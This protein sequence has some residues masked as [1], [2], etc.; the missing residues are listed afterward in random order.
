MDKLPEPISTFKKT[1]R[2]AL[3]VGGFFLVFVLLAIDS[4]NYNKVVEQS[5]LVEIK[6]T[7][8]EKPYIEKGRGESLTIY[9]NEFPDF[10]FYL[11]GWRY[12]AFNAKAFVE[13]SKK[14]DS[15]TLGI[16]ARDYQTKIKKSVSPRL[17]EKLMNYHSIAPFSIQHNRIEYLTLKDVNAGFNNNFLGWGLTYGIIAF[18]LF[19]AII[20]L[21][22]NITGA[23]KKL[24]EWFPMN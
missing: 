4:D 19:V 7:L 8:K 13:E 14:G 16:I 11:K 2:N 15:I 21:V 24:K 1:K 18:V 9:L 12:W 22:L 20:C 23:T 3:I 6:A 17:S 10:A 5:E